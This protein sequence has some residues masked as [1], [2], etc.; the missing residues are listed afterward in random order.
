MELEE[1]EVA[2][3]LTKALEVSPVK[4]E[5]FTIS[6]CLEIDML[7]YEDR[8]FKGVNSI[9]TNGVSNYCKTKSFEFILTFAP[10]TLSSETDLFAFLATY[11]QLH[12]LPN[13]NEIKSGNYFLSKGSLIKGLGFTGVYTAEPCYFHSGCFVKVKKVEFLWLI[14]IYQNEFEYIANNGA[15]AFES[16]LQEKDPDLS[17]FNRAP[18]K[19]KISNGLLY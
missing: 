16:F 19:L 17:L 1:S 18:L 4:A 12:F 14:P 8:P 15:E 7:E 13:L 11:L 10:K 9:I 5:R 3:E 2:R 6:N